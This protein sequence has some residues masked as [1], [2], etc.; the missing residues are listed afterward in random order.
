MHWQNGSRSRSFSCVR[1]EGVRETEY[2]FI[3]LIEA[4]T[5]FATYN[6]GSEEFSW[7]FSNAFAQRDVQAT[8]CAA[9]CSGRNVVTAVFVACVA[10]YNTQTNTFAQIKTGAQREEHVAL[11]GP[12]G[13]FCHV[14]NAQVDSAVAQTNIRLEYAGIAVIH[15]PVVQGTD[16][17]RQ[18]T[19]FT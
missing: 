16:V 7:Q 2:Q 17:V 9:F 6:V 3:F 8:E 5:V 12:A 11:V 1:S 19:C 14:V 18:A 10:G 4:I 15:V 13:I